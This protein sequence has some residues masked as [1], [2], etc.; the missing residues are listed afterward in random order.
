MYESVSHVQV[1]V[2]VCTYN[3]QSMYNAQQQTYDVKRT[4]RMCVLSYTEVGT[5]LHTYVTWVHQA[6]VSAHSGIRQRD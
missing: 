2:V 6:G 4:L 1:L 5:Q 3:I